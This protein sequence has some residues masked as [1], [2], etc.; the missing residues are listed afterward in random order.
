M[1]SVYLIEVRKRRKTLQQKNSQQASR[2]L[3]SGIDI[4][5]N[6]SSKN[7]GNNKMELATQIVSN[8]REMVLPPECSTN[9]CVLRYRG[10]GGVINF[11]EPI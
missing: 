9:A 4:G 6:Y 2:D 7:I 3:K 8:D 11:L 10:G 5:E 1:L